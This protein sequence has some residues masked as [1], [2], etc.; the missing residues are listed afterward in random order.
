MEKQVE[1]LSLDE[2]IAAISAFDQAALRSRAAWLPG[3][4]LELALLEACQK[5]PQAGPKPAGGNPGGSQPGVDR[6]GKSSQPEPPPSR[7]VS[8]APSETN[9]DGLAFED[10]QR[11]WSSL[12]K[13]VRRYDPRTQGLLNSSTALGIERGALLLGFRS[14]LLREK[15]EKEDNIA[16]TLRAM[17]ELFGKSLH[18]RC[19]LLG[20]TSKMGGAKEP[21]AMEEGG[22]VATAVRDFGAQV[23]DVKSTNPESSA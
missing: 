1:A 2:L 16:C 13:I 12:L 8:S 18:I 19:V 20:R 21:T 3:L 5:E 6:S 7:Q 9:A 14:D 10:I 4:S 11:N 17:E 15:M 23:V 22:M